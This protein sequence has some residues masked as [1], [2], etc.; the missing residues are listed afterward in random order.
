M[1]SKIEIEI[2]NENISREWRWKKII[3]MNIT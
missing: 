1:E 2:Y 3:Q